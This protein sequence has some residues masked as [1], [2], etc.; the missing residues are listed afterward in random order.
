MAHPES[1]YARLKRTVEELGGTFEEDSREWKEGL[2]ARTYLAHAPAG[3]LWAFNEK[4]T[5]KILLAAKTASVHTRHMNN[6]LVDA[7][8]V[9]LEQGF[10]VESDHV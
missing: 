2:F 7:M 8:T 5:V 1:P 6:R 10:L 4:R 9:Y 3:M